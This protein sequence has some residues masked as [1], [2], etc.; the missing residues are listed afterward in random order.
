MLPAGAN[1]TPAFDERFTG[2]GKNKVQWVQALRSAGFHFW[3][4]PRA[5][6][7]P[8]PRPQPQP[9]AHAQPKQVSLQLMLQTMLRES[10]CQAVQV[11]LHLGPT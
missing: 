2:Y 4:L 1:A 9:H 8:H 3:V 11:Q 7:T 5:R 10:A 6:L